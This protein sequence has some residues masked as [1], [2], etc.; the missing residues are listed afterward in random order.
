MAWPGSPFSKI[1]RTMPLLPWAEEILPVIFFDSFPGD[2]HIACLPT[3]L[4]ASSLDLISSISIRKC[5]GL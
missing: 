2:V 3:S 5:L 1:A 4:E